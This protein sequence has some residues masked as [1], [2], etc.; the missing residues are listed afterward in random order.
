MENGGNNMAVGKGGGDL[1]LVESVRANKIITSKKSSRKK[2]IVIGGIVIILIAALAVLAT[3]GRMSIILKRPDQN[4][5]VTTNVCD[6]VDIEKYNSTAD[7]GEDFE[8]TLSE[9]AGSI[10]NRD[11]VY[12]DPTCQFIL[13]QNSVVD[14]DKKTQKETYTR[15]LELNNSGQWI[16]GR[17]DNSRNLDAIK[18]VTEA[19]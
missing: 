17:V 18:M 8:R 1:G 10:K 9:L 7:Y 13:W 19:V 15:L 11:H 14:N 16:D 5:A 3:N 6:E 12:D 4:I 2:P